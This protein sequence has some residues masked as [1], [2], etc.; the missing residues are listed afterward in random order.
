MMSAIKVGGTPAILRAEVMLRRNG[1][2]KVPIDGQQSP[3]LRNAL[4][5]CF[6]LKAC[7]QQAELAA[8]ISDWRR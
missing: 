5:E 3:A 1:F 8:H 2:P 4:S 6:A 7:F